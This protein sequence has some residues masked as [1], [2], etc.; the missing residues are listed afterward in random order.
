[1]FIREVEERTGLS[2]HTIRYYEKLELLPMI[3]RTDAGVRNF[4]ESD[5]RFLSFVGSLKK[6]GMSLEH[7]TLFLQE[8]CLVERMQEGKIPEQL[9]EDRLKLLQE[10]KQHLLEQ[11]R[12][13]ESLMNAVNIKTDYYKNLLKNRTLFSDEA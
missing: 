9:I 11:Q 12:E 1:M 13:L 3:K 8:G 6:T 10:H 5:V 7:I 2:S 4:S